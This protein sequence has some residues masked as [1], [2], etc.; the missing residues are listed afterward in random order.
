[1]EDRLQTDPDPDATTPF[2]GAVLDSGATLLVGGPL[3]ETDRSDD[4][5]LLPLPDLDAVLGAQ[6]GDVLAGRYTLVET[7]GR[8]GFGTVWRACVGDSDEH[9]AVKIV[10]LRNDSERRLVR[11]EVAALRWARLPGVVRLLDDG[12]HGRE[13]F[14]VMALAAGAPFPGTG[15]PLPWPQLKPR[16]LQVLE[17]LARVHLSGLIHRDLKPQNILVDADGRC[18]L[19]DLGIAAGRALHHSDPAFAFTPH[20][21]APEQRDRGGATDERTDLYAFGVLLL[22]ALT[23]ALPHTLGHPLRDHPDIPAEVAETIARLLEPEPADR[24]ASALEVIDALGGQLPPFLGGGAL[25]FLPRDRP[26][27]PLELRRLFHGPELFF[28]LPE[29]AAAELWRRTG[30]HIEHIEAELGAWLR[31]GLAYWDQ[32]AVRITRE[33]IERLQSGLRLRVDPPGNLPEDIADIFDVITLCAP[34]AGPALLRACTGID[35]DTLRDALERLCALRLCWPLGADRM[36]CPLT[37]PHREWDRTALRDLKRTALPHLPRDTAL[38]VQFTIDTT[39]STQQLAEYLLT[40][41]RTRLRDG[42]QEEALPLLHQAE[43]LLEDLGR[44]RDDELL[45]LWSLW[46]LCSLKSTSIEHS[47]LH[48]ERHPHPTQHLSAVETLLRAQLQCLQKNYSRG[49]ELIR[50]ISAFAD[51][52]LEE[53]RCITLVKAL[54]GSRSPDLHDEMATLREWSRGSP[55]RTALYLDW[56]GTLKYTESAF[57]EAALY[58]ERAASLKENHSSRLG[59]LINSASA[60]MEALDFE[61]SLRLSNQ[62]ISATQHRRDPYSEARALWIIRT[63][64]Y[65]CGDRALKPDNRYLKATESLSS[66][67]A[68]FAL[69]ESVILWRSGDVSSALKTLQIAQR[70]FKQPGLSQL[71]KGFSAYINKKHVPYSEEELSIVFSSNIPDISVQYLAILCYFNPSSPSLLT[72]FKSALS[73][74]PEN[75]W[76]TILDYFSYNECILLSQ[77]VRL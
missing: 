2:P 10:R 43:L 48:F 60:Y 8:G 39:V 3:L 6:A 62:A 24:Y 53:W 27:T 47:L 45:V 30:G 14:I 42:E 9:V 5:E 38:S 61:K 72:K 21:A 29:D 15:A 65:R 36:G 26:A 34:H 7:I 54:T 51:L 13:Y 11:R 44:G 56:M 19:L 4:D 50:S 16:A 22:H 46:G 69:T 20:Y 18:T 35:D 64:R 73:A 76:D 1:M 31:A 32:T 55:R 68:L 52:D 77:G 23:G 66:E 49:L 33:A 58:H 28:H 63:S 37:P 70:V 71:I 25:D 41:I 17:I 59:S 40:R 12:T 74:R 75:E 67:S 57:Q